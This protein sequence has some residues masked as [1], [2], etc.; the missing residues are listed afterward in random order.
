ML[1]ACDRMADKY[2]HSL[3]INWQVYLFLNVILKMWK[4]NWY[5]LGNLGLHCVYLG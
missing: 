4:S 1:S 3:F 5:R 2:A